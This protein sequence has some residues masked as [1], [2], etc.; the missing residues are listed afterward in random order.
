M[1]SN[2]A[3]IILEL[4]PDGV[5]Y[6]AAE[7][8]CCAYRLLMRSTSCA[9]ECS[10]NWLQASFTAWDPGAYLE[11]PIQTRRETPAQ[12]PVSGSFQGHIS[13][14]A[15]QCAF[16]SHYLYGPSKSRPFLL[17]PWTLVCSSSQDHPQAS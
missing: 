8:A 11:G 7:G 9:L 12:A 14:V 5:S 13:A 17:S 1:L 15:L 3:C 2:I 10:S 4:I 6:P 16:P